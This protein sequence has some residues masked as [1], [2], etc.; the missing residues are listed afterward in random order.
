[1]GPTGAVCFHTLSD[2]TRQIPLEAWLRVPK[3]MDSAQAWAD[4]SFGKVCTSAENFGDWKAAILKFCSETKRCKM[5]EVEE[6]VKA[7]ASRAE[8]FSRRR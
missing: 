2:K 6:V 8:R 7:F 1:M 5:A 3:P 4:S